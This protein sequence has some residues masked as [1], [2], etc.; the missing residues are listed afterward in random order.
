MSPKISLQWYNR[1]SKVNTNNFSMFSTIRK[2]IYVH[3]GIA[4]HLFIN[5]FIQ[6][7]FIKCQAQ[8]KL[9]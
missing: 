1:V 9:Q 2:G 6:Q 7:A 8:C 3:E 5:L 4:I